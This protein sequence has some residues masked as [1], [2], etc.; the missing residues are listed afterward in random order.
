MSIKFT[1]LASLLVMSLI[2]ISACSPSAEQKTGKT[3]TG[4]GNL[5]KA[6][7]NEVDKN[8]QTTDGA[9]SN[10]TDSKEEEKKVQ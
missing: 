9:G 7:V 3:L 2:A 10:T 8:W 5:Y 6:G 4:V 1:A